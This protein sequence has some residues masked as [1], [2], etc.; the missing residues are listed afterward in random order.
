MRGSVSLSPNADV[1]V[2][3]HQGVAFSCVDVIVT[4]PGH[5]PLAQR[6]LT[7]GG[8][9]GERAVYSW[10]PELQPGIYCPLERMHGA[11]SFGIKS[12]VGCHRTPVTPKYCVCGKTNLE[13]PLVSEFLWV[14]VLCKLSIVS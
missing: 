3:T 14:L 2:N 9:P 8:G 12:F 4:A 1:L 13:F 7:A 10:H 5:S 11:Q 6:G